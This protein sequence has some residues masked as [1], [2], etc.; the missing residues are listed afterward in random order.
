MKDEELTPDTAE[1]VGEE[2]QHDEAPL[3]VTLPFDDDS[4][5]ALRAGE[6]VLLSGP[7]MA[8][9]HEAGRHLL[10]L[11]EQG[12]PSPI[13]LEDATVY[14][15]TPGQAPMG[16]VIGSMAPQYTNDFEE[17]I[18]HL[19]E[20]GVRCVIGRG[21]LSDEVVQR[22]KRKRG[23]YL[24][25]VGGA[26]ALLSRTV[27]QAQVAA[28]EELGRDAIRSLKVE[29]FPAVVA[30]DGFGRNLLQNHSSNPFPENDNEDSV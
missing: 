28:M 5:A 23:V 9:G 21:P 19:V 4:V 16:A 15:G 3:A 24:V 12:E 11:L 13:P 22:L 26:G 17:L 7:M 29:Q 10:D 25:S 8:L 27:Y 2:E 30:I 18:L 20:Q 6:W 14:F 1:E